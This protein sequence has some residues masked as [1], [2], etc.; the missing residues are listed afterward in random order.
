MSN[1]KISLVEVLEKR[2]AILPIETR[3]YLISIL[4]YTIFLSRITI[5]ALEAFKKEE[6]GKF[7]PLAGECSCHIRAAKIK[8]LADL[9]Y[10]SERWQNEVINE[11]HNA[12]RILSLAEEFKKEVV[13][14]LIKFS[15][16]NETYGSG[17]MASTLCKDLGILHEVSNDIV[18]IIECYMLTQTK[19]PTNSG[20]FYS[21]SSSR[22]YNTAC[23]LI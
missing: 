23:N 10:R 15:L 14:N 9:W 18:F 22:L 12:W 2:H 3:K 19:V 8:D 16:L 4:G 13:K 5:A 1:S 17:F 6:W 21:H 11:I 20:R 7:D